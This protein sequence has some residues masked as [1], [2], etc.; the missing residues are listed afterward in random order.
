[1]RRTTP[2]LALAALLATSLLAG[3]GGGDGGG[4]GEETIPAETQSQGGGGDPSAGAEV[5]ASAGCGGCHTL[6]AAGATGTRAPNL[7]TRVPEID[8]ARIVDQVTNGGRTMPAFGD[9][10][11]EGQIRDVAAYL[12]D[13]T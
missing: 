2:L 7:D 1:M 4:A 3:C 11:D 9:R 12:V 13:A 10:L 8:E 5:F 6:E